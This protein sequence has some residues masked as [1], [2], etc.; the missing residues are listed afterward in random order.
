M[1]LSGNRVGYVRFANITPRQLE[2]EARRR[3]GALGARILKK[4]GSDTGATQAGDV[5]GHISADAL[6][7]FDMSF[8][9]PL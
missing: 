4:L 7:Y 6:L 3:F 2:A 8:R 5:S 9:A 1:Q